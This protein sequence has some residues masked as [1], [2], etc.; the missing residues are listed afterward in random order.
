MTSAPREKVG[1][2]IKHGW[3][4]EF[5]I[6]NQLSVADEGVKYENSADII[7]GWSLFHSS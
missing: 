4:R 7:H 6:Q 3:L 1:L 5:K 2:Q